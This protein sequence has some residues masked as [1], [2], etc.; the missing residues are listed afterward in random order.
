[1]LRI[2]RRKRPVSYSYSL[3]GYKL[4]EVTTAN[5]LGEPPMEGSHRLNS[6]KGQLYAWISLTETQIQ[7]L[8]HT[9]H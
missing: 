9:Q 8:Q 2:T 1:M 5:N 3:K 6:E 4:E 7:K